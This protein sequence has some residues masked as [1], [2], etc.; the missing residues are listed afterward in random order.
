MADFGLKGLLDLSS[1]HELAKV[2]TPRKGLQQTPFLL[3]FQVG[4]PTPA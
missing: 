3:Y 2:R 1:G 4:M